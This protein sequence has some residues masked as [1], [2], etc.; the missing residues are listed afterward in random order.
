MVHALRAFFKKGTTFVGIGTAIIFQLLFSV[1]W[2]TGYSGVSNNTDQLRIVVVNEDHGAMGSKVTSNLQTNLPFQ[3]ST[4]SKIDEAQT[5]LNQRDAQLVVHIPEQ[6]TATL[7]A[8]GKQAVIDYTINESNASLIKNMMQSVAANITTTVNKE[9]SA[10]GT[11]AL[12]TKM[13]NSLPA[14]QA[15]SI[16]QNLAD[17]VA[18]NVQYMNKVKDMSNQM[19]PMMLTLASIVG[20]MIMGMNINQSSLAIGNAH[21]KWHKFAARNVI[22]VSSAIVVG[23]IGTSA[24]M[25]LG[26]ATQYG[27]MAM[28]GFE[29]TFLLAFMFVAQMFLILFGSA[30]M[31][32]NI[33]MLSL[34][35]VSSGAMIPRELL[36]S[37]YRQ[38]SEYMPATYAVDGMMNI[39]FGGPNPLAD[40]GALACVAGTALLVSVIVVSL[41]KNRVPASELV[42]DT[43]T[44]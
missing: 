33:A 22:N 24:V 37:F 23:L 9:A 7:A 19:I 4:L 1:I 21:S 10:A 34:Q 15:H 41:K 11:E 31:L 35:L 30:G 12:I 5:A 38:L 29:V 28:W 25:L 6:F 39:L 13:N 3:V 42:I 43:Q 17:K 18:S 40:A 16:A 8:A 20:T 36:S 14:E 26:G 2:M 44:A 27:F 32:L